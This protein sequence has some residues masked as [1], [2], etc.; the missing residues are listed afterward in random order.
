MK[1][2]HL[3]SSTQIIHMDK[4][5]ILTDPWLTN[6]EYY[7]SWYH[8]PPFHPNELRSLDYDF[9]YVSHIHPDHLSENTFKK[10]PLK[11]PVL[12]HNFESKFLKNKLEMLGFKVIECNNGEPY[13][14]EN[15]GSLTIFA[16][17]NCNPELC[18][19]FL[20]CSQLEKNFKGTQIDT[21]AL[22]QYQKYSILNTNDCPYELAY[23][24]ITDHNLH[25]LDIDLLLV[26]YA[27][28]GPYPQCFHFD[29]IDDK[30]KAAKSKQKQFLKQ[31]LNYINLIRP[32]TFAPFAGTYI[33]GS[34]LTDL[35]EYRGV[36]STLY[37]TK[38]LEKMISDSSTGVHFEKFDT[39]DCKTKVLLKSDVY[40]PLTK[41]QFLTQI[42]KHKLDY[43]EDNWNDDELEELI[44]FASKRFFS[45]A[46]EISFNSNTTLAIRSNKIMFK[47]KTSGE[48]DI[49]APDSVIEEPF[50][51][52]DLDHRLLHRLLRGPRYAHWNNA[53]I[54]SHLKFFRKPNVF[55]RGLYYCLCFLHK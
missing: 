30:R 47:I 2:C 18:G 19:K 36:P 29:S 33:L 48:L 14:F 41:E 16:A 49:I 4:I 1:I 10:L 34:N 51:R 50:V 22:F 6:G 23:H 17:D 13:I 32:I 38:F 3:Q 37:A 9:I 12:I 21:L 35:N 20:G 24:T 5:K 28:A 31:A 25:Q 27:G 43:A 40:E 52:I 26:G 7:G 45:K 54:G 46:K 39:Y 53:E 8:Y 44:L 42:S 15:G 55:E 11:R